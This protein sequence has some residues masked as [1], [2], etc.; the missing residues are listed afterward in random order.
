MKKAS[1][2]YLPI[3]LSLALLV[4]TACAPAAPSAPAT[5]PA[6]PPAQ[7]AP[8]APDADVEEEPEAPPAQ[9]ANP[10]VL[11]DVHQLQ[12]MIGQDNVVVVD[13]SERSNNVITGAIWIDRSRFY[14]NVDSG[15]M[16]IQPPEVVAQILGEHGIGNDTTVVIYCDDSNLWA[17]RFLWV[18]RSYGHED[19]R[20]L[21]GGTSAWRAAGGST[22]RGA[23][24]PGSATTFIPNTD[25][26]ES[27][28]ATLDDVIRAKNNP[29][30]YTILDVRSPSEWRGG[31]IPGAVQFTYPDD[32]VNRD[33]TF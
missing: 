18:L 33:G 9:M 32:I 24:Q 13:M 7:Q 10:N 8:E 15:R 25:Y 5:P 19:I 14:H 1:K 20:I 22:A 16:T 4:A 3:T 6:A 12:E 31:R 30:Q 29:D 27:K 26:F 21:D 11:I 23:G 17:V 28:R 2:Y